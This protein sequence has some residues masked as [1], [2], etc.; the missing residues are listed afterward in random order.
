[1]RKVLLIAVLSV[2]VVSRVPG[3]AQAAQPYPTEPLQLHQFNVMDFGAKPDGSTLNTT[4]IGAAI[5]AASKA[6]GGTVI[7]PPGTYVT[8]TF[9]LASN[10]TLQLQAGA[11]VKGS[12][13]LS[14]YGEITD[15]GLGRDYGTNSSGEGP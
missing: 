2:Q 10:I 7:F 3:T 5:A 4:A 6:G 11:V 13:D 9:R 8:G 1:M 12:K 14:D 15:Y